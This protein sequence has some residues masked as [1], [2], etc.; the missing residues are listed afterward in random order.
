[1]FNIAIYRVFIHHVYVLTYTVLL[2]SA[3]LWNSLPE[4][5]K[6]WPASDSFK[7]HQFNF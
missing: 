3:M 7:R 2:F 5:L 4:L 1:M 6:K